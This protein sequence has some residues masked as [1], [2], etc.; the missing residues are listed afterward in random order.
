MERYFVKSVERALSNLIR[1]MA[2]R[3]ATDNT[4]RAIV[5]KTA[6]D[7]TRRRNW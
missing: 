3:C 7:C 5:S 1:M 4:T 6:R 2:Q